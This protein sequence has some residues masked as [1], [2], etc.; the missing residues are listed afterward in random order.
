MTKKPD[1]KITT[2]EKK[3]FILNLG[4][5]A[6]SQVKQVN[7][8]QLSAFVFFDKHINQPNRFVPSRLHSLW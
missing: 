4:L 7:E 6:Q 3:K 2:Y 8:A 5:I 1:F